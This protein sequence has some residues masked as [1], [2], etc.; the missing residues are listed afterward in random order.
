MRRLA[1]SVAISLAL[2]AC[3]ATPMPGTQLGTFKVV[4]KSKSNTCGLGAPDPWTFDVQLSR[5]GSTL[6]WSWMDGS[7]LVSGAIDGQSHASLT[8]T[9][10]GNLDGTDAGLGPCTM[11]RSD[12]LEVDLPSASGGSF[13]GTLGYS[14]S[15][16]AGADCSDQL[17]GSGGQFEALPCAVSYTMTGSPQ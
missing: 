8:N 13:T 6:Y 5:N 17:T 1:S 16:P 11:Q 10:T 7:P 3:S 2:V 9:Q 12:D 15:V 4:A 14:F